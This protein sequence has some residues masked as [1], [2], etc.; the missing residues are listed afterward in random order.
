MLD[1]T[2]NHYKCLG[3]GRLRVTSSTTMAELRQLA[4]PHFK[5]RLQFVYFDPDKA[6]VGCYAYD[7]DIMPGSTEES[8]TLEA[9]GFDS[10]DTIWMV[11][12][13]DYRHYM[14]VRKNRYQRRVPGKPC[15][16]EE[17]HR[18]AKALPLW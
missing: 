2:I 13:S 8:F 10:G 3:G 5:A 4:L 18:K 7:G 11:D 16:S 1:I 15:L 9:L 17:G 14:G 12:P 6:A